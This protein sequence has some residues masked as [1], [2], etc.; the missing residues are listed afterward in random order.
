[1]QQQAREI[2]AAIPFDEIQSWT[3]D[4]LAVGEH[5]YAG[6]LRYYASGN[7]SIAPLG[8]P[9]LRRYLEASLLMEYAARRLITEHGIRRATFNHG[10]YVPQG[11]LGEVCR[12]MGDP[13]AN[14]NPA[15]RTSCFLVRHRDT[16]HHTLMDQPTSAWGA[17]PW[18][19]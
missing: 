4:G 14:R 12:T 7:L 9:V 16:Y 11:V 8:E 19:P 2:A 3:L 1:E 15:Y 17:I 18:T 13:I 10:L 5:A 6:A